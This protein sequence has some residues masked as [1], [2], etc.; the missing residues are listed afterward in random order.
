MAKVIQSQQQIVVEPW[1]VKGQIIYI[2]LGM[3]LL[4][5]VLTAILRQ[6][7]V[8]PIACRDLSTATACVNSIGVSGSI[9][10]VLVAVTGTVL[11]VRYFQPRPIIVSVATM[12]L[13]WDLGALVNGLSWW[14]TLLWALFFYTACYGLF[15]MVSRIQW[16]AAGLTIAAVIVVG[17]RLLVIL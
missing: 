7:V 5:W 2:G 16:L 1:W 4:W 6:Y 11:L 17:I 10:A 15:S 9:A 3:G 12:C 14:A 8:E 13:L